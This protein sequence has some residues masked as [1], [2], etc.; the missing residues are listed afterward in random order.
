[1][2]KQKRTKYQLFGLISLSLIIAAATYGFAEVNSVNS[3]GFMGVGYGVLSNYQVKGITYTLDVTNPTYF[4][5][6]DFELEQLGT[7]VIAGVSS[8]RKGQVV[9]ADD[10]QLTST[11]WTCTFDAS[12]DVLEADWLHVLDVE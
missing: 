11:K 3:A 7:S 8:T 9:W 2:T 10:C 12:I 6:V 5:A 1:M 4:T